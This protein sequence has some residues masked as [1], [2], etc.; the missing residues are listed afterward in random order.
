MRAPRQASEVHFLGSLNPSG[1][2][3]PFLCPSL[4]TVSGRQL[5]ITPRML[6]MWRTQDGRT[7]VP[8]ISTT[9]HPVPPAHSPAKKPKPSTEQSPVCLASQLLAGAP[10][11]GGTG[12]AVRGD[13]ERHQQLVHEARQ[14]S[15]D[16]A[17]QSLGQ[18]TWESSLWSHASPW[19]WPSVCV[20]DAQLCDR[21]IAPRLYG[22]IQP[23]GQERDSPNINKWDSKGLPQDF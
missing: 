2:G 11:S 16:S 5:Q 8:N 21:N 20:L 15:T 4:S 18:M 19:D 13:R 9:S 7:A 23:L 12:G 22:G 1:V 14:W 10:G 3:S 6:P 17:T